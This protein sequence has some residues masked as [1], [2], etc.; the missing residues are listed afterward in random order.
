MTYYKK[1][2]TKIFDLNLIRGEITDRYGIEENGKFIGVTHGKFY[3]QD[4]KSQQS[5]KSLLNIIPENKRHLFH[6]SYMSSNYTIY[7][8]IDDGINSVVNIYVK[9]DGGITTFHKKK[10]DNANDIRNQLGK[11]E[12]VLEFKDVEDICSFQAEVGDVYIV[13]TNTLHS[14]K[15]NKEERLVISMQSNL[16]IDEV[17]DIFK[18]L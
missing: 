16:H 12:E 17:V 15:Q 8:H 10:L 5:L 18:E 14:V 9:A 6:E 4:K 3:L 13:N 1:L 7:P 11:L 2:K